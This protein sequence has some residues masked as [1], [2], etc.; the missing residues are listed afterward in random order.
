MDQNLLFITTDP[1]RWDSL[2]CYGLELMQTHHLD[3]LAAEGMVFD[4]CIGP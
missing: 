4:H 1:Q 3:R 2:P